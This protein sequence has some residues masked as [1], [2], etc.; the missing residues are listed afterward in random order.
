MPNG[1][2]IVKHNIEVAHRLLL[3]KGRCENIHGHSMIVQLELSGP[4]DAN[5]C[6]LGLD[7]GEIKKVFRE[8]LD[9]FYDHHLL[10]H[11]DDYLA[12]QD[13]PGAVR[14]YK[15][16]PTTE[17]IA[18]TIKEWAQREWVIYNAENAVIVE[19]QETATNSV[20]V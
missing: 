9:T 2:L 4:I 10:L 13:L 5:D 17:N 1:T 20:R 18:L 7:F 15:G 16:D 12:A 14:L 19:V 6:V 3:L 11:T 8:Y